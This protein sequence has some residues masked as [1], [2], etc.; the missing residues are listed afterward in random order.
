MRFNLVSNIVNGAGL[1]KDYEILRTELLRRGHQVNGIQFN[2][3]V[4]IV[5][6]DVNVFLETVRSELFQ[7]AEQ[8]W[9][10]PN[11]EWWGA[12]WFNFKF[13]KVLVKTHDG[14]R[15]FKEKFGDCCKYLGW[16]TSDMYVPQIKREKKFL[17]VSGKSSFKNTTAILDAHKLIKFPLTIISSLV[18]GARTKVSDSELIMLMNNHQFNLMP[19]AY[20][21]YGHSLHEAFGVGAVVITTDAPPMNELAPA[22]LVKGE[23]WKKYN[24]GQLYKVSAKSVALG[25][26]MAL[27]LSDEDIAEIRQMARDNFVLDEQKFQFNLD[28]VL[29]T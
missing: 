2:D 14:E 7:Y 3:P 19:S 26:E 20:E 25:I 4:G 24:S 13:D 17:H 12:D 8:Q 18:K 5:K 21:G 27:G 6:S 23:E 28:M 22:I 10:V 1:Q 11:P 9:V 16:K 29:T 15:I